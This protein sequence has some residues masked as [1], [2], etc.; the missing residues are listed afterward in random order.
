MQ[1]FGKYLRAL[2]CN[3]SCSAE[4]GAPGAGTFLKAI[5]ATAD[6]LPRAPPADA[7]VTDPHLHKLSDADGALTVTDVSLAQSSLSTEDVFVLDVSNPPTVY[8]WIGK[9]AS[10][11][12]RKMAVH[13]GQ[14]YLHDREDA[15][16]ATS[17]VRV[18]EGAEPAAFFAA[19]HAQ[20]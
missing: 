17:V 12:E 19:F 15:Q 10:D 13:L 6:Q 9:G 20:S 4:E 18:N 16:K 7:T 14:K 8:V 1:V 2:V 3:R 11:R 5:G